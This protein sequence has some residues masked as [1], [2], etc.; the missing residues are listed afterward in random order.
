MT[1]TTVWDVMFESGSVKKEIPLE[2]VR[3][4][5]SMTRAIEKARSVDRSAV[6]KAVSG[7]ISGRVKSLLDQPVEKSIVRAFAGYHELLQYTD[8]KKS[9]TDK[10]F[11]RSYG[12]KSITIGVE[13]KLELRVDGQPIDTLVFRIALHLKVTSVVLTISAGRIRAGTVG[14]V[15]ASGTLHI[16]ETKVYE[17]PEVRT[18]SGLTLPFGDGVPIAPWKSEAALAVAPSQ[19]GTVSPRG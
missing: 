5:V 9:A 8:A 14:R 4:S 12:A 7:S 10:E 17:T 11:T 15:D 6:W 1:V 2:K 18:L 13:P 3:E 19:A 16:G